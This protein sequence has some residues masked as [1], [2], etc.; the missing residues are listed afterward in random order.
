MPVLW[1]IPISH[2]NEKARWALDWK[3]IDYEARAPMPGAHMAVALWL[4]RGER[5]TFPVLELNGRRIGDSTAIIAALEQAYPE[6]ALYPDD[7]TDRRRA[8]EI[9]DWFDENLGPDIRLLAWHE[10]RKDPEALAATSRTLTPSALRGR[11]AV[12]KAIE[13]IGSAYVQIRFQ[14]GSD[15]NAARARAGV[16]AALDRLEQELERSGGE[17][18]V[19]DRFSVADLSVASLMY[20]LVNPP[21]GPSVES[22]PPAFEEFRASLRERPGYRWVEQTFRRHRESAVAQV[23]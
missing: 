8:L 3:G 21:E 20:P 17:Y 5:K 1:H 15:E 11:P 9:E 6:P 22:L 19:G 13:R 12:D 16:L 10:I 23:A 4:T 14:V 7:P 2:Y 18:L